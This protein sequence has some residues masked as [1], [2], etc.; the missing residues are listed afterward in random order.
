[1]RN[2]FVE[3][4]SVKVAKNIWIICTVTD[5]SNCLFQSSFC[6]ISSKC[7]GNYMDTII[8]FISFV[9]QLES[10]IFCPLE[11]LYSLN[12]ATGG[13]E[14][15]PASTRTFSEILSDLQRSKISIKDW[16]LSD[17]TV[18]LYLIYL[19]QASSKN[20][21]TFKGVQISSNKMVRR[22]GLFILKLPN[23]MVLTV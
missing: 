10:L 13:G 20:A 16:S 15:I 21:E 11:W 7:V 9:T 2:S 5:I 4:F 12:A 14:S 23:C 19:S 17:L 22:A 6:S 3:W 1:M 8:L 18:G